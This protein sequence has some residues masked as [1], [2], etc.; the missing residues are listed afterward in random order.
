MSQLSLKNIQAFSCYNPQGQVLPHSCQQ[1]TV[2]VY[3]FFV[4]DF[5]IL[6]LISSIWATITEKCCFQQCS[7]KIMTADQMFGKEFFT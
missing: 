1:K 5:N 7:T 2:P 4:E 6:G 3:D